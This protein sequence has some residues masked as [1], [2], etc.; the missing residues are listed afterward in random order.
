[1]EGQIVNEEEKELERRHI[2]DN[3]QSVGHLVSHVTSG[4]DFVPSNS[5]R[6]ALS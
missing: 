6:F 3:R 1:M 5:I 2:T 4:E